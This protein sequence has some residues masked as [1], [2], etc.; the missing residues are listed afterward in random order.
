MENIADLRFNMDEEVYKKDE[1]ILDVG[2][3]IEGMYFVLSGE[4]HIYYSVGETKRILLD[5]LYSRCTYGYHSVISVFN[6]E[7]QQKLKD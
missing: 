4:V 1:I 6:E 3:D 7:L 2:D 5:R